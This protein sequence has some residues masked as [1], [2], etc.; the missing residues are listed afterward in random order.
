MNYIELINRFW[1][2]HE[3]Y[4]FTTCEI[5]VYFYLLKVNNICNWKQSFK[6]NNAKI[7]ADLGIKDRRT[8]ENARNRLKQSGLIDYQKKAT[9]PNVTYSLTSTL[10]AQVNVQDSVEVDVQ[11]NAQV[12]VQADDTK[13]KLNK[14]KQEKE[15]GVKNSHPQKSISDRASDFMNEIWEN[16]KGTEYEDKT[17][18][19]Q[20]FE[21]WSEHGPRDKK[22]RFEKE[23]SFDIKR[24]LGTW[25]RND[26]KF[27]GKS[28]KF[29]NESVNEYD[30]GL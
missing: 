25:W 5:A 26:K 28:S 16:A 20:F 3:E 23:T 21:Y 22:M 17:K 27:N 29:K 13:D 8:L 9:N 12:P 24:R 14:T 1:S 11:E 15:S 7:Q 2:V 10:N 30:K 6:R 19:R 4:C 18:L